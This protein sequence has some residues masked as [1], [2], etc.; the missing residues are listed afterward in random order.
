LIWC[1]EHDAAYITIPCY[2]CNKKRMGHSIKQCIIYVYIIYIYIYTHTRVCVCKSP[3]LIVT[4][5]HSS[6]ISKKSEWC[7][8]I[9]KSQ[10]IVVQWGC[11]VI[12]KIHVRTSWHQGFGLRMFKAL[13]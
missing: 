10:D 1:M 3:L 8:R 11:L 2:R 9:H 13:R 5:H 12:K 4:N 7:L 6:E